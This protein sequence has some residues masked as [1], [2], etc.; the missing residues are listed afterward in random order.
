MVLGALNS[1]FS[2]TTM[3]RKAESGLSLVKWKWPVS[4]LGELILTWAVMVIRPGL[5]TLK[6]ASPALTWFV[7]GPDRCYNPS[8]RPSPFMP[9]LT[10]MFGTALAKLKNIAIKNL[11]TQQFNFQPVASSQRG[12]PC[13]STIL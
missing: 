13:T 7:L 1:M 4:G 10:S 3:S 2:T 6:A 11:P 9:Q 8:T 12:T 5:V